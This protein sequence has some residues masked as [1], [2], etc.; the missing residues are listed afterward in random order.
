MKTE[1]ATFGAGCFWHVEEAFRKVKGVISTKVGFM[2]GNIKNPSYKEVCTGETWHAEA[3]QVE[4]DSSVISYEE[5]LDIFWKIHDPTSL[6][7]QGFDIGTQYRS[8]IFYHNDRQKET[9]IKSREKLE[10]SK[11]YKNKI[12]TEIKPAKEFYKAEEYHQKY[13]EKN[14][15]TIC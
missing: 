8:A 11:K 3:V 14:K 6:N 7:Q 10:K 13:L 15:L 4:F 5:L 9:A 2:G 1:K 12:V